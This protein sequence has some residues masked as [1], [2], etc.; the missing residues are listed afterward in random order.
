MREQIE[1]DILESGLIVFHMN[2]KI[3]LDI[4]KFYNEFY[5]K[6]PMSCE[7]YDHFRE[8][9]NLTDMEL[10]GHVNYLRKKGLLECR[11]SKD[12]RYFGTPIECRISSDGIDAIEHPEYFQKKL[13]LANLIIH[14]DV[15]HSTIFQ[16][17][18]IRIENGFNH[19]YEAIKE[20]NLDTE[21]KKELA[22]NIKELELESKKEDPNLS[23]MSRLLEKVK[24]ISIPIYK[25]VEPIIQEIIK[26]Y[27]SSS[28]T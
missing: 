10:I 7:K 11:C 2:D 20:S 15:T 26:N 18:N 3:R 25:F 13:P 8:K 4:L 9:Y 16:A 27:L 23:K 1:T 19:I 22:E 28:N 5:K 6:D 24:K 14:G 17:E 12:T 21:S